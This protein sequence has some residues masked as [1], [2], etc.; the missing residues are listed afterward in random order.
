MGYTDQASEVPK[1][2]ELIK[3]LQAQVSL[4]EE[5]LEHC[6]LEHV[7]CKYV[8]ETLEKLAEIRKK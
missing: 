5:A 1:M 3:S 4:L 7:Y 2:V 8:D 6:Q